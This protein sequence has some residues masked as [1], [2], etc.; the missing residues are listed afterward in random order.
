MVLAEAEAGWRNWEGVVAAL[1]GAGM[2]TTRAPPRFW[3][4]LGTGLEAVEDPVGAVAALTRFLAAAPEDT[5]DA[6][7]ARSRLARVLAAA[8]ES[9]RALEVVEAL[10]ALSPRLGEWT[11]LA[12]ART[13]AGSGEGE[14][15][16]WMLSLIADPGVRERGWRLGVD[17]WARA[18]DTARALEALGSPEGIGTPEPGGAS[19]TEVLALR[20]RFRLALGDSLGAVAAME[21][22]LRRTTRGREAVEAAMAHW[23]VASNSGPEILR[24][25]AAAMGNGGEYGTA[26]RAWRLAERRGAVLKVGERSALARAYN[27]SGDRDGA[28]RVYRALAASED[29]AIAAPALEAWARIRTRQGRHGDARILQDR[30]VARFPARP[31]ALNVIFLRGDDHQDAGRFG[32]AIDHYGRVVS[33]SS[34]ANRAGLARMRWAQIHVT[35]GEWAAARE[36]FRGYLAEFPRGRRWEE[37]SYWGARVAREMGDTAEAARLLTRIRE[38]S[39]LSYYAV[40]AA[41]ED[42]SGFAPGFAEGTPLPDPDWLAREMRV[43]ALLEKAGLDEAADAHVLSMKA[44]AGDSVDLLLR[45]AV[46]LNGAGRTLDGIRLGL[47]ARERGRPWD[48]TLVRVVYPFP[49]RRLVRSR[50]RELG[51]DPYLL[52]GLIRQESAFVPAIVSRAGAIG[53]MQVM[54]A[55]GRQ[56]AAAAGPRNFRT[57]TLETPELNIHLGAHFLADLLRRYDGDLPLVLSAYNAGPT[58][59]NRWRHFPEAED[60]NRFTERIP[61]AETRGYVKNVTRNRALYRWLYAEDDVRPAGAPD[62]GPHG[63]LPGAGGGGR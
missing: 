50:A 8:G 38:E 26:V 48:L 32:R 17:A 19:R 13:L 40:L 27:G 44:A 9:G 35:R 39:P 25:V 60:P 34:S 59:A 29:A 54:P 62:P 1:S 45:L 14:E 56:L 61:F 12:A 20:W 24:R 49:Y 47:E 18:G 11:A 36:I 4:L 23:K 28:V 33:M 30:L 42:G 3:Y 46:A 6:L 63:G 21:E 58:R 15:V 22:L 43:L 52:A 7:A 16:R 2:D 31:E 57:E 55:T 51:L 5:G 53:L 41:E 37:A 10:H